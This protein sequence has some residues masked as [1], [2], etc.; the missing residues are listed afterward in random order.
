MMESQAK[1]GQQ[2]FSKAVEV[3]S[4]AFSVTVNDFSA[5]LS[6]GKRTLAG[7]LSVYDY[8]VKMPLS[9]LKAMALMSLRLIRQYESQAGVTISLPPKLL[10]ALGI[11]LEDWQGGP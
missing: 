4:D 10:E 5:I 2:D 11:P 7:D 3:W 6:L 1:R 9:Q 8:S